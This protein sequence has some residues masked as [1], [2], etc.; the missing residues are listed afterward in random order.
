MISYPFLDI[1]FNIFSTCLAPSKFSIPTVGFFIP[2]DFAAMIPYIAFLTIP[3][4]LFTDEVPV[5]VAKIISFPFPGV[6]T[7][8]TV[9][10]PIGKL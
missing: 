8:P 7:L 4:T 5:V 2:I 9:D 3:S 10:T 6:I 1:S